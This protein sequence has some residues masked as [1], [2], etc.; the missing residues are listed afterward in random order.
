MS[1]DIS[2]LVAGGPRAWSYLGPDDWPPSAISVVSSC[3]TSSVVIVRC[4]RF[5]VKVRARAQWKTVVFSKTSTPIRSSRRR[6]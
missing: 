6:V 5:L 4:G 3:R 2:L 1:A